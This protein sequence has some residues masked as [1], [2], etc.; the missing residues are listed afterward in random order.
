MRLNIDDFFQVNGFLVEQ[1]VERIES[2]VQ[3]EPRDD[4]ADLFCG[5]GI[6]SLRLGK[7]ARSVVG[8]EMNR[9]AVESARF[10]ARWNGI[11]NV[12]FVRADSLKGLS[13]LGSAGK[14][15]V[16]PPRAG[17]SKTLI[18]G[19]SARAPDRVVYASCDTA[20]F[21]RDVAVFSG[22]GYTLRKV[23]LVDMF[24]RTRHLE[25][26]SLLTRER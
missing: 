20:T 2:Y 11:D 12:S 25:V 18:E 5:S 23:S 6:L 1:W 26:V 22:F 16:D 17:L 19:I 21:A 14:V 4:V 3:P 8:V 9:S 10:N 7:K 24:P 15:V 13:S